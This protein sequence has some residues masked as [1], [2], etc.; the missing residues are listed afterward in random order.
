MGEKKNESAKLSC[1]QFGQAIAG[2]G[3]A[4][5]GFALGGAFKAESHT[6]DRE[7][8]TSYRQTS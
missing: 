1:R 2:M 6:A 4:G 5:T 3:M 8:R 7:K